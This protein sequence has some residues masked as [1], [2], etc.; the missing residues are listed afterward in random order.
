[1]AIFFFRRVQSVR[2][3]DGFSSSEW[4]ENAPQKTSFQTIPRKIKQIVWTEQT[5][6]RKYYTILCCLAFFKHGYSTVP[7]S[8]AC[9][10]FNTSLLCN[11]GIRHVQVIWPHRDL[12]NTSIGLTTV[13]SC[14]MPSLAS[15]FL[16]FQYI[17]GSLFWWYISCYA[18]LQQTK[19]CSMV[20]TSNLFIFTK[21]S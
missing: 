20:L 12:F 21:K 13:G 10:T 1:M 7:I 8:K 18:A 9:C 14:W 6:A 3:I 4:R 5:N 19:K 15:M 2:S 17:N 11:G 16:Q